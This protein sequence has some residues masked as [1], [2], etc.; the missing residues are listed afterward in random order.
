MCDVLHIVAGQEEFCGTAA[1]VASRRG[2]SFPSWCGR[3]RPYHTQNPASVG[4]IRPGKA[5]PPHRSVTRRFRAGQII[6]RIYSFIP[7][8][9]FVYFTQVDTTPYKVRDSTLWYNYRIS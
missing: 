7:V 3:R 2:V 8:S 1:A 6:I 4:S 9:F 5:E